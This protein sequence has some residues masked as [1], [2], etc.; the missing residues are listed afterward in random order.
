[1][2]SA[3]LANTTQHMLKQLCRLIYYSSVIFLVFLYIYV[4][5]SDTTSTLEIH[6]K[7]KRNP[8]AFHTNT[9]NIT[10]SDDTFSTRDG[11]EPCPNGTFSF[12]GWRK[13]ESF[14]NCSEIA[15]QV[16]NRQRIQGGFT[17]QLWLAEWKGHKVAYL[18]CKGAG[19]KTRCLRG[20]TRLEKLQSPFVTRLIG[21]CYEKLEV[22]Y[23]LTTRHF[24][25][26]GL[27][28]QKTI[29]A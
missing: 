12:P 29:F 28:K 7:R 10:C 11:C 21:K 13:C 6:D 19:V 23:I 20:M 24:C 14:L 25:H 1:M 26:F 2:A 17:K 15:F 3:F 5:Y 9:R 22:S 16:Q 18:K 27:I 8:A 4:Y